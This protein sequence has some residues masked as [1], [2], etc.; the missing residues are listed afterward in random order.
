MSYFL[1]TAQ[2]PKIHIILRAAIFKER[3]SN[4]LIT[5]EERGRLGGREVT[6]WG[7]EIGIN[8]AWKYSICRGGA[9]TG[10]REWGEG[11]FSC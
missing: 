5:M 11:R 10:G 3:A 2:F 9:G 4:G 6:W 1:T 8:K 7:K